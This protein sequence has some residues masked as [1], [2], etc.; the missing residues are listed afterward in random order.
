MCPA[1]VG[2]GDASVV[3]SSTG[4][5]NSFL[6]SGSR[7]VAKELHPTPGVGSISLSVLN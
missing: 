6:L 3:V 4:C 1:S 7:N 2:V 5:S